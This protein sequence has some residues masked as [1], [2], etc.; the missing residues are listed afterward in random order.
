MGSVDNLDRFR[1][2]PVLAEVDIDAINLMSFKQFQTLK[3]FAE[4]VELGK[5]RIRVQIQEGEIVTTIK[6][7][8]PLLDIIAQVQRT[9]RTSGAVKEFQIR[10]QVDLVPILQGISSVETP[11]AAFLTEQLFIVL[12][13]R[14][15]VIVKFLK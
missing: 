4:A 10:E 12:N 2:M 5:L 6:V 13:S 9:Y 8:S 14:T 1:N 15:G 3:A 11:E 7:K